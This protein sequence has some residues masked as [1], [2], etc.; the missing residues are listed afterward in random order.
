MS[1]VRVLM[2]DTC[3]EVVLLMSM[4]VHI[5][6]GPRSCFNAPCVEWDVVLFASLWHDG[7]LC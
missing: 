5:Y 4:L 1:W 2:V 6:V 3:G 7:C